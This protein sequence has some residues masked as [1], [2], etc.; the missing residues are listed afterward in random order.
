MQSDEAWNKIVFKSKVTSLCISIIKKLSTKPKEELTTNNRSGQLKKAAS[1]LPDTMGRN[2]CLT[3]LQHSKW[4]R[5]IFGMS[6]SAPPHPRT[7]CRG[8]QSGVGRPGWLF[9]S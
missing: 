1:T 2:R 6:W 7:N 8:T 5:D 4:A 9:E 3:K